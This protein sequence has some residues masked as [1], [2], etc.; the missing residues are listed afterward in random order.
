MRILVV[1]HN[2]PR[3]AGDPAG[4]FVATLA[5]GVSARG[6]DVTVLTPHVPGLPES[7]SPAARLNV[8]RFRYAPDARERVGYTGDVSSRPG[9][10]LGKAPALPA[11]FLRFRSALRRTVAEFRPEVVHAHWWLPSGWLASGL[12]LPFVVTCH[13]SDVRLLE[14]SALLRVLARPVFARAAA[15]TAVSRFLADDIVRQLGSGVANPFVTPMPVDVDRFA[16]GR[17]VPKAEPPRILYAGNL[18][19]A[20]GVDV[21]LRAVAELRRRSLAVELK[22]LG[23]GPALPVL[24][25]LAGELGLEGVV[26]WSRFLPQSAMPAE[27]GASTIT[28]LPSRGRAEGLGLSLV[29]ALL[30]GCAVVGTPVGGI[31]EVIL[32]EETGLLARDGDVADLA[33]QLARLLADVPLRRRLTEAGAARARDAHAPEASIQRFRTLYGDVARRH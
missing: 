2:Y 7:E 3:F 23:E 18:V 5:G 16:A 19:P 10:L 22:V 13:G 29:E 28:V 32:H 14:R 17:S 21:L 31:P 9:R 4:A 12:H 33:A 8:V 25:A 1:T 11:Y 24:Q 27:Y 26:T 15:T 6:D 30:A 20:K